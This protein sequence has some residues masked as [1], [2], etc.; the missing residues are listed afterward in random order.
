MF[1]PHAVL[2]TVLACAWVRAEAPVIAPNTLDPVFRSAAPA[3]VKLYGGAIGREHGFGSGV[4]VSADGDILTADALLLDSPG[5]RAVLH[6]GRQFPAERVRD[7]DDRQLALLKIDVADAPFLTPSTTDRLHA[8][9]AVIALGNWFKIAEGEEP[10]S[11]NRGVLSLRTHL[12]ARR[13]AQDFPYRGPVLIYDA[14]TSNPGAA[15]GPVLDIE[16]RFVGLIGRLVESAQTNTRINYALP[17]EELISFL[18][19][20]ADGADAAAATGLSTEP[21]PTGEP[22]IGITMSRLGYRQ[23]PAFVKRVRPGSPA[24]E[25]GIRRDDLIVAIDGR[26]IEDAKGCAEAFE[27]LRPGQQVEFI[28][29]RGNEVLRSDLTVGARGP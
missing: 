13:L 14:M 2:L 20:H 18:G 5:L 26:R 16:G 9:D 23:T 3:V 28:I 4:L 27:R 12:D 17:G 24:D 22:D 29:K 7:D 1:A 11:A 15:G 8:G 25:A 6:D 21:V 10:V 19:G